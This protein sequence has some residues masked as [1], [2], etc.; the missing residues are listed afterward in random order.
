MDT[1]TASLRFVIVGH[2]DHGKSTLIGRLLYET[3]SLPKDK[4]EEIKRMSQELGRDI[5]FSFLLDHLEE[6]RRQ[7]ITIDTTQTF[8]K[9]ALRHYVII[10]APGHVEFVRNMV[11]GS[12]Q[13]EA[14]VLIIDAAEGIQ[15]QTRR[16]L[17]ILFL[18]DIKQVV[19][20]V[21]KMDLVGF[22]GG[23]FARLRG[24]IE[25]FLRA[26]GVASI[27]CIP[28]SALKGD[29]VVQR[30]AAM[31][32][33]D[34]PT[35]LEALD[36]LKKSEPLSSRPF[37]LP[38]Q[39][40]YKVGPK[41]IIAGKIET[42]SLRQGDTIEVFPTGERSVVKTI[43]KFPAEVAEASVEECVGITLADP[44]FVERGMVIC[45]PD[46]RP[47][48]ADLFPATLLWMDKVP[49]HRGERLTF[50]CATQSVSC[51]I[52]EISR[53]MDSSSLKVIEENA[54]LL[55]NLEVGTVTI[56]TERPVV[57]ELFETVP[58]LGRF[59]LMGQNIRAGGL[60]IG[61]P[62]A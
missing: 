33:Y 52:V 37:I 3:G 60:I 39:D 36:T 46:G 25:T 24:E 13:A 43:E 58:A 6:E 48:S 22:D 29:N 5:E 20:V 27:W 32:W 49:L 8:L 40:V 38:V 4:I 30:S 16:H 17:Y 53:R 11:T 23:T 31:P 21:N 35:V 62:H 55:E 42:G 14:G 59:V 7:G 44:L 47:N 28:I 45:R 1:D 41:R 61:I 34:G 10:D 12:S 9:T 54:A 51:E 2:V 19:V 57:V 15:E 26:V 56:R 18:L 50:K